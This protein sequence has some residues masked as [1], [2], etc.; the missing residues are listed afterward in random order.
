MDYSCIDVHCTLYNWVLIELYHICDNNKVSN[1]K[2]SF[3]INEVNI[4]IHTV[5]H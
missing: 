4:F 5:E 2:K 3:P 1:K